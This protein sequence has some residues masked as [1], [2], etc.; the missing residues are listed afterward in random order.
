MSGDTADEGSS[1]PAA[2]AA[3]GTEEAPLLK[4]QSSGEL[5]L[6]TAAQRRKE[7]RDL[8]LMSMALC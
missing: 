1:G 4:L 6:T 8:M 2:G 7:A 5:K 3:I